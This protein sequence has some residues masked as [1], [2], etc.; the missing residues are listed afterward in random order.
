MTVSVATGLP[1]SS[2]PEIDIAVEISGLAGLD[3]ATLRERWR[4]GSMGRS[5]HRA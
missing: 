4:A 5:R 1:L 3:L 2:M